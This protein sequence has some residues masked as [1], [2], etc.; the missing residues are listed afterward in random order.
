MNYELPNA[1]GQGANTR[2]ELIAVLLLET[3]T[4]VPT[5]KHLRRHG[6]PP[7]LPAYI[8]R[9]PL[10]AGG[11]VPKTCPWT[12]GESFASLREFGGYGLIS[13]RL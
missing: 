2:Q 8:G 9:V 7:R 13:L 1:D 10:L 3:L 6:I 4:V 5:W 11:F 12:R